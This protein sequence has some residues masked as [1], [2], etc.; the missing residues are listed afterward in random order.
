M[1]A[2][3]IGSGNVN[4]E[5]NKFAKQATSSLMINYEDTHVLVSVVE[6]SSAPD[7]DF[8]PLTVNYEEKLYALGKIP[9]NYNRRE[10]RPSTQATLAAR[11]IDRPLRPMFADHYHN[12]VQIVCSVVS[13][14]PNFEPDILSITGASLALNLAPTIPFNKPVSGVCVGMIDGEFII[15]PTLAQKEQSQIELKMA[16]SSEAI[17]MV[18]ASSQEVSEEVMID[19]L[20]FGHEHIKKLCAWQQAIIDQVGVEK[21]PFI[22]TPEDSYTNWFNLITNNYQDRIK[23]ALQI[24]S[25]EARNQA[26]DEVCEQI[27]NNHPELIDQDDEEMSKLF[28]NTAFDDVK[29]NVFRRLIIDDKHRVDGRQ[30]DEIRPLSSEIDLL[31]RPHGSSLFTRGE[32]Q[33][34]ATVTLGVMSDQQT[35]DGF[36]PYTEKPLL[37]HYNFPPY[38]VGETG[39]MGAPGRREIGH[40]HLGEL[41]ISQVI[42]NTTDFPY[43]IRV[44]SEILESNGS[45]S[46]AT[47]CAASLALMDAGVPIK[48]HVAGIA[49][50]LIKDEYGYSILT[51]IQGLEDH[52]GDMD[53]K[54]AGTSQGICSIQMDIKIDGIDRQILTTALAQAKKARLQI[55]EHMNQIISTPRSQLSEYAPKTITMQIK[56]NK[57]KDVIGKGG[58]TINKIIDQTGVK[59]DIEE[60]GQVFIYGVDQQS[61]DQ[62]KQMI[63]TIIH[64]YEVGQQY[65]AVVKRIEVYG[66]FVSFNDQEALL[67]ISDLSKKRVDKVEDV[68]NLNEEI[69]VEII[70]IDEKNRIKVKLINHESQEV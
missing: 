49:M 60:D 44:V 32:T 19:A 30:L 10:S 20:M 70:S 43:T 39:R 48:E 46:Q 45:S 16:G 56:V 40:G 12:E 42:P 36:E 17:V 24:Q 31:P 58:E 61:L 62:A 33:S 53:F 37:L 18:E 52:L 55:L 5:L 7:C 4:V 50:G 34:L 11:L 23:Q 8:F 64:E 25:K 63:E 57:I 51:D 69:E 3:K 27:I 66:A 21:I 54:V 28:A 2:I 14:D 6:K 65:K 68:I 13:Y 26:I 47:I 38:S 59:I 1:E 9:G 41:A 15:N 67:H 29:K 22:Y 35:F